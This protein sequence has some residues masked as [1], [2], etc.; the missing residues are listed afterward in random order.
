MSKDSTLEPI[1]SSLP[2]LPAVPL[3]GADLAEDP[4]AQKIAEIG[5]R[6]IGK[7]SPS[8]SSLPSSKITDP[9]E[10]SEAVVQAVLNAKAF[11]KS[12]NVG[13]EMLKVGLLKLNEMDGDLNVATDSIE[14]IQDKL[15]HLLHLNR[16]LV[17]LPSD[18][19]SHVI[20][21]AI[22]KDLDVLKKM[23]IELLSDDAKEISSEKLTS[24]KAEIDSLKTKFQSDVQTKFMRIQTKTQAY[25]SLIDSLKIIERYMSRLVSTITNNMGKR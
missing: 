1:V 8:L 9:T 2:I 14:E 7:E 5:D 11:P 3:A 6:L 22:R 23:G 24:L 17:K 4:A 19:K 13:W 10:T 16:S 20:T 12:P 18:Q 15:E 21:D 25:N